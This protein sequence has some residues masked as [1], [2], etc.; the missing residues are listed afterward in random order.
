MTRDREA[1]ISSMEKLGWQ[2]LAEP[3]PNRLIE[4]VFYSHPSVEKRLALAREMKF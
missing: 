3:R 1:F 4:F 2:N